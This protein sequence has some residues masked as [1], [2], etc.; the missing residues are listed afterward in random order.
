MNSSKP[1]AEK[2]QIIG[3]DST[4]TLLFENSKDGAPQ[5][6][7]VTARNYNYLVSINAS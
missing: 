7:I 2:T 5:P 3:I 1:G 6:H 4:K